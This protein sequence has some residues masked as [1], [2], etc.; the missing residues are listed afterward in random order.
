MDVEETPPTRPKTIRIKRPDGTSARKP[1]TIA[2]PGGATPVSK[3]VAPAAA[4]SAVGVQAAL[5]VEEDTGPGALYAVLS[6]LALLVS[7]VLVYVLLGQT[8]APDWPFAGR[9]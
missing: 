6:I 4:A 9:L 1:L 2:R 3:A 7:L 5:D 8:Y